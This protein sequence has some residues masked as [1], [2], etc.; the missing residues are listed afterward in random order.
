[1]SSLYICKKCEYKTSNYNDLKKHINIKKKCPKNIESIN[2]SDD[3]LLIL[4]LLPYIDNKHII[5]ID[6][7]KHLNESTFLYKNKKELLDILD[8]IDKNKLKKCTFC[9][10]TFNKIIDLRKHLLLNCFYEQLNK[11]KNA[12]IE[13]NPINSNNIYNNSLN[14]VNTINS[15]NIN[16]NNVNL[17]YFDIKTPVSFDENW[18]ISKI[19]KKSNI[20]CSNVMYTRLLKELLEN[21][22]NLNVVIDN[23][24]ESGIVY[25]NNEDKYIQMKSNEI[26]D[27]TMKKLKNCLNE[28][29]EYNKGEI[30]SEI[31]THSR[32]IIEKKHIDYMKDENT[33]NIVQKLICN[34]YQTKKKDALDIL[35]NIQKNLNNTEI[36]NIKKSM[37]NY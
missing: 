12:D 32:R 27:T 36:D 16:N 3:Q 7:V 1:M 6:E 31:L 20:T 30:M 4:S 14:T 17:L 13:K 21:E 37:D 2:Y 19:D 34:I 22:N 15:N 33:K 23:E 25:K 24:N 8:N 29:N 10:M 28:I 9:E 5:N 18:D 26:A 35:N 11:K